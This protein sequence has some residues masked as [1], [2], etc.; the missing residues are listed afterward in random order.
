M[1]VRDFLNEGGKLILAGETVGYYGQLGGPLGGIYYG[2]DGAPDQDCVVSADFFSDCLLLADDFTQYYLGAYGRTPLT[3]AGVR[4]TAGPLAGGEASFGGPAT[5]DNPVDEAGAF[6]VTSDVLPPDEFPQFASAAAAEYISPEGPFFA[7]EGDY[8]VAAGHAD[9]SYMRVARTFDL[10]GIAAPDMPTFEAQMSWDTEEGYDHVIV[11]A[12]V[13]GVDDWTTLPDLEGGTTTDVPAECEVGFLLD[14]HP[15]LLRYLTPW[16]PVHPDRARG[17]ELVHRIVGRLD[18]GR[19]R[20]QR[21]RR[22]AG[23]GGDQLRHRPVHGRHR[24]G[25]RRH[26]PDHHRRRRPGAAEGFE[27]GLGAWAVLDAPDGSPDNAANFERGFGIGGITVGDHHS[28]HRPARL[29]ARAA[30]G[31]GCS[32]GGGRRLAGGLRPVAVS[33]RSSRRRPP[34]ARGR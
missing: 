7:I 10:T 25:L 16:R 4:A 30:R 17:V 27:T 23:R 3:A 19:V 5:A 34:R 12:H 31:S 18:A 8:A 2:L 29:R 13:V 9:D 24:R 26:P 15:N 28:R 22:S 11:E 1:A 33:H 20:P 32:R 6:V 21:L 14:E